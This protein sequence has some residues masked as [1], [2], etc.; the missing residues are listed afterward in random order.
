MMML[1]GESIFAFYRSYIRIYHYTV[2]Y[3]HYRPKLNTHR[4]SNSNDR[5][6]SSKS[7]IE[8]FPPLLANINFI[9]FHLTLILS[10]LYFRFNF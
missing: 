1:K 5:D 8:F 7:S 9:N 10:G 4:S 6:T 3:I 2:V